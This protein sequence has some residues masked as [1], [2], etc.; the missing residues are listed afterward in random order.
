MEG[1]RLSP[2][3][4]AESAPDWQEARNLARRV[5]KYSIVAC[6]VMAGAVACALAIDSDTTKVIGFIAGCLTVVAW[7]SSFATDRGTLRKLMTRPS[8]GPRLAARGAYANAREEA[9]LELNP[10]ISRVSATNGAEWGEPDERR[11]AAP[12]AALCR[13]CHWLEGWRPLARRTFWSKGNGSAG[14]DRILA[15]PDEALAALGITTRRGEGLPDRRGG[16]RPCRDHC[17]AGGPGPRNAIS[18]SR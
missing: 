6:V 15:I 1:R 9:A 13:A 17:L 7:W 4:L 16:R 5:R 12:G 2:L 14:P 10:G 11:S 3:F 8:V 18:G